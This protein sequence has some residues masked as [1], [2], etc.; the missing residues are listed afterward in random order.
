MGYDLK[1]LKGGYRCFSESKWLALLDLAERHRWK[2]Q[3][4]LMDVPDWGG[5]YFSND[6]Q[7]VTEDDANNL[8]AALERALEE[9]EKEF[10]WVIKGKPGEDD[11]IDQVLNRR[12]VAE[13]AWFCR[14]GE[15]RIL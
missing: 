12:D 10:I 15:F 14:Q 9:G 6:M 1:N 7:W 3:G 4:T 8:A 11:I 13:F 5:G 2:P